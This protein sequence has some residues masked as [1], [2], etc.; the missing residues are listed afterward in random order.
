MSGN[1]E[2]SEAI[3]H[4]S[5]VID[6]SFCHSSFPFNRVPNRIQLGKIDVTEPF[7]LGLH[8]TWDAPGTQ[9]RFESRVGNVFRRAL[10]SRCFGA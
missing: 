10:S 5:F 6:L 7:A 4:S 8:P 3:R 2:G 9:D 1:D